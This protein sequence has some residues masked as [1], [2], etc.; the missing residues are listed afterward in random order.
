MK[1]SDITDEEI[2]QA[3]NNIC[4]NKQQ[5]VAYTWDMWTAF[6]NYPRKVV[7]AKLNTMI[8]KR[9]LAGCACGCR[10]DFTRCK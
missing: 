9:R 7:L 10:G 8:K 1:S 6:S 5:P 4:A 3:I 2:Y